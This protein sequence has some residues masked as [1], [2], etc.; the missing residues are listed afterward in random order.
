MP[1]LLGWVGM[2]RGRG[3]AKRESQHGALLAVELF[4]LRVVE[5]FD[6]LVR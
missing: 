6:W 1:G 2:R 3:R 5:G 4:G